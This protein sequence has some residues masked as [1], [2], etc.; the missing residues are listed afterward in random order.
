MMECLGHIDT[1][2]FD[3]DILTWTTDGAN[4][5]EVFK[6][7]GKFNCQMFVVL[8]PK[9]ELNLD[10]FLYLMKF[11]TPLFK[12]PD[13]NGA[14]IMNGEM[15]KLSATFQLVRTNPNSQLPRLQNRFNRCYYCSKRRPYKK[16][17]EQRQAII[18]EAVTKGLNPDVKLKDSGI[19]WLGDIPEH[20]EV[21]TSFTLMSIGGQHQDKCRILDERLMVTTVIWY[22][23]KI[24]NT[25]ITK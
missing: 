18:N 9:K 15:V 10:Y 5:G 8:K 14:K 1:F 2:D 24:S 11:L 6:R 16:L 4:A 21:V 12:R 17:K 19:E 25:K 20:W 7:N 3:D 22:V 13:T 23:N